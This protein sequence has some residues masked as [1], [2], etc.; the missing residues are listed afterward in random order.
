[1]LTWSRFETLQD[2]ECKVLLDLLERK[3]GGYIQVAARK[4]TPLVK[5]LYDGDEVVVR[6]KLECVED[7]LLNTT[8]PSRFVEL[9]D[10]I[11]DTDLGATEYPSACTSQTH[12]NNLQNPQAS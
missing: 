8:D 9:C 7:V 5:A 11:L 10:Q 4:L 1:M 3:G 2:H 12:D 6:F